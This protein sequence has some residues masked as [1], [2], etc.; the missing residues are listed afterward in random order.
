LLKLRINIKAHEPN[1][2]SWVESSQS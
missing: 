1:E 2:P